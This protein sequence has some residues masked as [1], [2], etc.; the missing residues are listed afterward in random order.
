MFDIG[1]HTLLTRIHPYQ[2]SIEGFP[3]VHHNSTVLAF[4][5]AALSLTG[6]GV[7]P[8]PTRAHSVRSMLRPA[9]RRCR[10]VHHR[11][12]RSRIA[13]GG[14][15]RVR[16]P[17]GDQLRMNAFS[18]TQ[19]TSV[20]SVRA[21][22]GSARRP[23]AHKSAWDEDAGTPRSWRRSESAFALLRR[24]PASIP[25]R[26]QAS[27]QP[28]DMDKLRSVTRRPDVQADGLFRSIAH[29]APGGIGLTRRP[30]LPEPRRCPVPET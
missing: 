21:I 2:L 26:R 7:L 1:Y 28:G 25:P 11:R 5:L 8:R 20:W 15:T 6:V 9:A 19:V 4:A 22:D 16:I 14:A 12:R 23:A 30:E 3:Y 24:R 29:P 17:E 27:R 13:A 18:G 10:W